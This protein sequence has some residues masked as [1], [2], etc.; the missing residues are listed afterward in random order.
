MGLAYNGAIV[1]GPHDVHTQNFIGVSPEQVMT[2]LAILGVEVDPLTIQE[3]N[4]TIAAAVVRGE[5]WIIAHHNVHS[6]YLYHRDSRMRDFYAMA[7][8]IHID[9]IP[10]LLLPGCSAISCDANSG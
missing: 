9:G 10:L 5:R 8:V 2:R 3:L 7:K 1:F 4:A 6:V